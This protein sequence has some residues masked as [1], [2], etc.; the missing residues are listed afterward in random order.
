MN[1]FPLAPFK[2]H[3]YAQLLL[4]ALGLLW[5]ILLV[6][7]GGQNEINPT[8]IIFT[9]V[10]ATPIAHN[11]P[12]IFLTITRP[13]ATYEPTVTATTSL[14]SSPTPTSTKTPTVVRPTETKTITPTATATLTMEEWRQTWLLAESRIEAV[15]ASNNGCQ[16]PCWWGIELGNSVSDAQ[17]VFDTI[18][19]TGWVDSPDEWGSLQQVGFF[20]HF[21]VDK[22]GNQIYSGLSITL[23]VQ[24]DL[25]R[26]FNIFVGRS[27]SAPPG[28]PDYIQ[29]SERLIRDWEQF[30]AQNMFAT[31][32]EPD[33]IYLFPSGYADGDNY[34]YEFNLYYLSLGIRVSYASPLYDNDDNDNGQGTMCLNMFDMDY[35]RLFLYDPAFLSN[36]VPESTE[37]DPPVEDSDLEH[38]TG[39]TI[40]EFVDYIGYSDSDCFSVK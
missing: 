37:G 30:S 13:S 38:R 24:G 17:Q 33:L 36:V 28:D 9:P 5:L 34:F 21:Y 12:T 1:K 39:L 6:G 7:C 31:F 40:E 27:L 14:P 18:N 4:F 35:L 2:L 29:I 16:L 10:Q 15:M 32:G 22:M 26:V 25:I 3:R 19:P 23:L 20:H 11:S 8:G